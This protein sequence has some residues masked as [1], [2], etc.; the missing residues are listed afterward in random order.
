LLR[1]PAAHGRDVAAATEL[2]SIARAHPLPYPAFARA[3]DHCATHG[4]L[5]V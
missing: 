2:E 5:E 3:S 4:N 1:K